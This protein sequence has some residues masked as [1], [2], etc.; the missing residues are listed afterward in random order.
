MQ[1]KLLLFTFYLNGNC[2]Q[3]MSENRLNR[4]QMFFKPNPNKISVFRTSLILFF[5]CWFLYCISPHASTC[6]SW[7]EDDDVQMNDVS[8]AVISCLARWIMASRPSHKFLMTRSV[9]IT[10]FSSRPNPLRLWSL[11]MQQIR[12]APANI[13]RKANERCNG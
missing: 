1:V 8:C 9:L 4:C 11:T 5:D 12:M 6:C 13:L 3:F 2:M 7:Y 10:S